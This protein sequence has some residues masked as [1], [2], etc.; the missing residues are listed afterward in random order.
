M[1]L[2]SF[3]ISNC[4]DVLSSTFLKTLKKSYFTQNFSLIASYDVD[5]YRIKYTTI[6]TK[7]NPTEASGL[8]CLPAN[9]KGYFYPIAA[10]HHGTVGARFEVPSY[11]SYEAVIPSILSCFGFIGIAPDYLGLGDSPGIHPYVHAASQ[12]T[13][14]RD[15]LIAAVKFIESKG[16]KTNK[17]LFITGYSQGGHAGMAFHR[18]MEQNNL[19]FTLKA[20]SHMSGPYNLSKGMKDLLLTNEEYTQVAYLANTALAY[21]LVY[22]IFPDNDINKFFKP[23]YANMVEKFKNE[24]INLFDMNAIMI[25]SLKKQFGKA[26][27]KKMIFDNIVE[28]INTNP[29]HP[30]NLALLDNDV[31]DWKP[32]IPTRLLY[33]KA[34]EQVTYL[35]TITALAKMKANGSTTVTATDVKTTA[36]HTDCV[37]PALTNTLFFFLQYQVL[38]GT[39]EKSITDKLIVLYPNP[40]SDRVEIKGDYNDFTKATFLDMQ[41]MQFSINIDSK[42]INIS[43]LPKGTY[44]VMFENEKG[45]VGFSKLV[46]A[47]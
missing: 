9:E 24:K 22:G 8:I 33:C 19:G 14:S 47:N 13:A 28:D 11:E 43:D 23:T 25:D 37:S 10:Y 32:T 12:A 46:K 15:L 34:D 30:V 27:P 40:A 16:Y 39:E 5:Q 21:N 42:S 31:Y 6:D 17:N 1:F 41:G 38:T 2:L 44:A 20:A 7:G 36:L 4:Q 3:S 26:S 45:A 18:M 29:N 35:N